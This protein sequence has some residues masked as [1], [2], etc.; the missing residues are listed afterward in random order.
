MLRQSKG[1]WNGRVKCIGHRGI[2]L[3]SRRVANAVCIFKCKAETPASRVKTLESCELFGTW[4]RIAFGRGFELSAN[5]RNAIPVT[6]S[7]KCERLGISTRTYPMHP[8][9]HA[10]LDRMVAIRTSDFNPCAMPQRGSYKNNMNI[11]TNLII[12]LFAIVLYKKK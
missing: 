8:E 1:K 9:Y 7:S 5:T 4:P 3:S 11:H 6:Y 12:D 2:S 10:F